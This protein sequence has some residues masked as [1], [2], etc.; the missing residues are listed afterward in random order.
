V[1][2]FAHLPSGVQVAIIALAAA[3]LPAIITA[4]STAANVGLQAWLSHRAGVAAADALRRDL[5]QRYANPLTGAA[6]SLYWRLHEIF[7]SGRGHFLAS[8]GGQTRLESHKASSTRYRIAALLGWI[9]AL[10]RELVLANAKP[11]ESVNAI[12]DAIST[13]RNSLAEGQHIERA[14]AQALA[15][16]WE[17]ELT[18]VDAAGRDI[19]AVAKRTLQNL[20]TNDAAK[21]T[22]DQ[23]LEFLKVVAETVT[24]HSKMPPRSDLIQDR[25][26]EALG[27]LSTR[28]AWIY[29][30]WQ[31]AI[32]EWM[33]VEVRA[34]ARRY[35]VRGYAWFSD[36]ERRDQPEDRE[37]L[38]R[39][40]ELTA[41]LDVEAAAGIDARVGQLRGV[42]VALARLI[43]ELH[44]HEPEWAEINTATRDAVGRTVAANP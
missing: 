36:V 37:W 4:A 25:E 10:Q 27:A 43:Q 12:R 16:I 21:L 1:S 7:E 23:R 40:S 32:G 5:Y 29:R 39:L 17:I 3:V 44:Q 14:S 41:G 35:D 8:G 30:D 24:R 6:I 31:D 22:P 9:T 42:Y 38:L 2:W 33:L 20:G 26:L 28:E 34:A 13:V 18:D 11:A 19:D 15:D